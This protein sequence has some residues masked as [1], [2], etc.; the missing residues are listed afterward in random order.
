MRVSLH[1]GENP[2]FEALVWAVADVHGLEHDFTAMPPR[3][4]PETIPTVAE[5]LGDQIRSEEHTS[6]LQSQFHL[7]CRL[8]LEKKKTT[9]LHD[10]VRY[11]VKRHRGTI[12]R[13]RAD[14]SRP[15][16]RGRWK[17]CI[18]L[19]SAQQDQHGR[20]DLRLSPG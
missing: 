5:R 15:S 12:S 9:Q 13:A 7:V 1:Q 16:R 14:V 2:I 17:P 11:T 20:A 6:E 8:L 18:P 3:A 10:R 4:D 19:A